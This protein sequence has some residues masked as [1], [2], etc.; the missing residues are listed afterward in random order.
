MTAKTDFEPGLRGVL[1]LTA[2][3]NAGG[4]PDDR[5]L[6]HRWTWRASS[7]RRST[8]STRPTCARAAASSCASSPSR[9][10]D[11]Q[12]ALRLEGVHRQG[13]GAADR[14]GGP[15]ARRRLRRRDRHRAR[16]RVPHG[17]RLLPRQ[18]QG[19]RRSCEEALD[20]G[21]GRV[22]I[23]NFPDIE[24][25]GRGGARGRQPPGRAAAHHAGRRP[26]HP[27]ADHHRRAR[28]QVRP[29]ASARPGRGGACAR[30]WPRPTSTSW[31]CTATSARR[32]SRRSPTPQAIE[33]ALAF[34][35]EM[36]RNTAWSCA[37]SAPAAASACS[38]CATRRRRRSRLTPRRSPTR[39]ARPASAT[40]S[41]C[42]RV[43][44]E[45]GRSIV[46]RAGVALYTRRGAQ[47]DA[48]RAHLRRRRWRH[49]GQH[50]PRDVRLA[51]RGDLRRAGPLAPPEETVTIVGKYCESGDILVRDVEPAAARRRARCWRSRPPAPTAWRW[52]ATT[53]PRCRPAIVFV[54]DGK[55]RLVR[56]RE[57]YA[58]LLACEVDSEL[59]M[60]QD[61]ISWLSLDCASMWSIIGHAA[62]AGGAAS[63]R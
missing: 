19:A 33:K 47:G 27:R 7:A 5:R 1:P 29:A 6:R 21:V 54:R 3:V 51:V 13:A 56:R 24:L 55:A 40:A 50:P 26:P 59:H 58:D 25:L 36:A 18:Q 8:S 14:G 63:A 61:S 23:D 11:V 46:G 43:V 45:P 48:G 60:Q 2:A 17:T 12:R 16:G 42:P 37:S 39:S 34:A 49:G 9:L 53:T 41:A 30:R 31:A 4:P 10:P 62:G 44:V 22:V 38:T 52:R 15:R 57:T 20:A 35:A 28:Q 32:S